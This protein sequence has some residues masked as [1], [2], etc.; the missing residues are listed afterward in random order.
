MLQ[1]MD[2][3]EQETRSDKQAAAAR[4]QLAAR[5]ALSHGNVHAAHAEATRLE[6]LAC[7]TPDGDHDLR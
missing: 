2:S 5:R 4:V 7:P 6:S 3:K 1:A